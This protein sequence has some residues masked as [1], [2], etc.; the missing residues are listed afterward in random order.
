[1]GKVLFPARLE[2][3]GRGPTGA[4]VPALHSPWLRDLPGSGCGFAH[5]GFR[6]HFRSR[7]AAGDRC[8]A[9]SS[10]KPVATDPFST[11][12]TECYRRGERERERERPKR[13]GH[14]RDGLAFP[15]QTTSA[16]S[17][18]PTQSPSIASLFPTQTTS[19]DS[20]SP[21]HIPSV[22]SNSHT[23]T[24]VHTTVAP[25]HT[26]TQASPPSHTSTTLAPNPAITHDSIS[27]QKQA[28]L[29][30][31]CQGKPCA[32]TCNE[33]L[34]RCDLG[35]VF[36]SNAT[37]RTWD[38]CEPD[39]GA[40]N[41]VCMV[42]DRDYHHEYSHGITARGP[43]FA[44]CSLSW[45][46]PPQRGSMEG[47]KVQLWEHPVDPAQ[48]PRPWIYVY[49]LPSSF[50][51]NSRVMHGLR[52]DFGRPDSFGLAERF[53]S[54]AQRTADPAEADVFYVPGMGEWQSRRHVLDY[55]KRTWPAIFGAH[56]RNHIWPPGMTDFGFSGYWQNWDSSRLTGGIPEW[57]NGS[58]FTDAR[59]KNNIS[60]FR[61][62]QDVRLPPMLFRDNSGRA[63]P[64]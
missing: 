32:G 62:G 51:L 45:A 36:R 35:L 60:V 19:A 31:T 30:T 47:G 7:T 57:I 3:G 38:F 41:P 20:H 10:Q 44:D 63:F 14:F 26:S 40:Q 56:G 48:R 50:L 17:H 39:R 12:L 1:M 25:S 11:A 22:P 64:V 13:R 55:V 52:Y 2:R 23:H 53:F 8:G 5:I 42:L 27:P 33:E 61:N 15:R 4:E 9:D 24:F 54:A 28:Q 29:T 49:D 21:A 43:P 6:R 16:P 58:I 37:D 34:G 18:S 59:G 46:A